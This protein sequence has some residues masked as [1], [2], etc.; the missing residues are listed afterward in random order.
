MI[1]DHGLEF[2][3]PEWQA[4]RNQK[5]MEWVGNPDA[6]RFL[7][8]FGDTCELFDDIVDRDVDIPDDHAVRVLFAVLTELPFNRFFESYKHQLVPIIVTGINAWLDSTVLEKGSDNDKVFAYVLR[9][10]YV[11][12]ISFIIFALRGQEYLRSVSMEIRH[13]F[14]HHETLEAY[15]E[16]LK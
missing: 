5:L 16:K 15:R 8:I 4:L 9:D 11:E 1:G 6:L 2:D 7:M 12:L 3:T 10:W 14:T 13:F